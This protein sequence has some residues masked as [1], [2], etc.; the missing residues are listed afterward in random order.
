MFQYYQPSK[1]IFG[2]GELE[3]LPEVVSGYGSRCL[4]VTTPHAEPLDKL[5]NRVKELLSSADIEVIHFDKVL[6]NPTVEIVNEGHE[7]ARAGKVDFVL[8][9]GGGSSIDTAKVIAL[10]NGLSSIDWDDLLT[11]YSNPFAHYEALSDKKLPLIAV[12]TT[13]GTGSQVTQAAVI[14]R[15]KEK[16][17]IFHQDNFSKQC[18]IDPE[19]MAT[20]PWKVTAA[21]G[22]DAFT[23]AFESYIN[24]KASAFT[25]IQSLKAMELVI[26]FLPK[27]LE[28]GKNIEYRKQLA[29][30]DTLAGCSLANSGASAPHPLSEIIGGVTNIAHGEA[31][32][33]VFPAFLKKAWRDY[34]SKFAR[35]A[36]LFNQEL[37]EAE[38]ETAAEALHVEV[39][40]FLKKVGLCKSLKEFDVTEEQLSIILENPVLGFLPFG[41]KEW[42]QDIIRDSFEEK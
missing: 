6:P 7:A 9:V 25:E 28:E 16:I 15:G 13:S 32:A 33:V 2:Q 29:I 4:L 21:T 22:F 8:A 17:T 11:N 40:S 31:L 20:L 39:A 1:I 36:R 18:I 26:R 27:A 23:H 24:K 30:A 14:T 5:F 3:K 10:T 19:L 41:N 12:P 35:V 42:L 37:E 34:T 38:E